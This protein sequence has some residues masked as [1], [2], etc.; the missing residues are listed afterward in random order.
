MDQFDKQVKA[1]RGK[2]EPKTTK[3]KKCDCTPEEWAAKLDYQVQGY[4]KRWRDNAGRARRERLTSNES[5]ERKR[6]RRREDY[7]KNKQRY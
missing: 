7:K 2:V 3:K 6:Q 4:D 1:L 5:L